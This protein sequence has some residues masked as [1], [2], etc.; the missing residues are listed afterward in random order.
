MSGL[1]PE[2]SSPVYPGEMGLYRNLYGTPEMRQ[3]FSEESRIQS[4]LAFEAALARGQAMLGMIPVQAAEEIARKATLEYVP[5][6]RVVD[7]HA[8]T[9][10]DTV[11]LIR[12]LASACSSDAAKYVHFGSTTTDIY[13]SGLALQLWQ[14]WRMI[15]RDLVRLS[16]LLARLAQE[17][18]ET[19]MVARTHSQH[20]LPITL[21]FRF[22]MWLDDLTTNLVRLRELRPRLLVGKVVGVVGS[23]AGFGTDG[24]RLQEI[25]CGLLGLGVPDTSVQSSR[26]RLQEFLLVLGLTANLIQQIAKDVWTRM[27]PEIGE[28][29]ECFKEGAQVGSSTLAFKRNPTTC[30]WLLGLSRLVRRNVAAELELV[31][32]DER[33]G[34]RVA[35]EQVTI[36]E[37]CLLMSEMLR[38]SLSLLEHLEVDSE[39]MAGNLRITKGFIFSEAIMMEIARRGLGKQVAYQV[40]HDCANRCYAEP[41][42]LLQA[43]RSDPRVTPYLSQEEIEAIMNPKNYLGTI[44]SQ[45]TQAVR[46][47][48][49][50]IPSVNEYVKGLPESGLGVGPPTS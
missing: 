2:D 32:E 10:L 25:V 14:A 6:R 17:H 30:E 29:R 9:R 7:L 18:S 39:R 46:R 12:V 48:E 23:Q 36:S 45:I 8:Q 11:A 3:V 15:G 22:A 49:A 16:R 42:D 4:W 43:L 19:I 38:G 26:A 13:D 27:R 5:V 47:A 41:I 37:S 33:D 28:L 20:A 31:S 24:L 50:V 34:T 21:G 35:V 1:G 44:P 40:L